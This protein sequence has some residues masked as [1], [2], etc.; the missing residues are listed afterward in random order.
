MGIIQ[1]SPS[2]ITNHTKKDHNMKFNVAFVEL[3][4]NEKDFKNHITNLIDLLEN[5]KIPPFSDDCN[6]CQ[7]TEVNSNL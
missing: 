6:A 5:P 3:Q 1:L 2:E 7:F 4:R